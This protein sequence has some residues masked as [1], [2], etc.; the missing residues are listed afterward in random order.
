MTTITRTLYWDAK[1]ARFVYIVFDGTFAQHH[2]IPRDITEKDAAE[3]YIAERDLG[4]APH[5]VGHND[6]KATAC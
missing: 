1:D 5:L 6:R 2:R 4:L 3:A